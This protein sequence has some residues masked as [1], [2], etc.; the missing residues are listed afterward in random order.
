MTQIK[1]ATDSSVQLSPDEIA[2][3]NITIVPLSLMIDGTVYSDGVT[4]TRTEFMEKMAVAKALPKT[5]Q[6]PI[7]AF[8]DAYDALAGD[9]VE[10][11]SIHM[12]ESISGTVHSAEQAAQLS[13]TDVTVI[14]SE[15]TDRAMG[16]QVLTA[17][18]MAA[19]GK[20]M[21][22]ILARL[23]EIKQH[24]KLFLTVPML[25]N[26]VAGGRL[27]KAVGVIGGLLNIKV[28]IEVVKG[29]ITIAAKGR[30]MKT[31]HKY[32]D[33]IYE[34]MQTFGSIKRI[35]VSHAGAL[36]G[37]LVVAE[38]VRGMFPGT[39]VYIEQTSPIISTHVGPGV[40][41]IMYEYGE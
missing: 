20:S 22:E 9:D 36:E 13:K 19:E 11:L 35:G 24:T 38:K 32:F 31:I 18:K 39:E 10:V 16:F 23:E 3:N 41:A 29:H 17:A 5:S 33:H 15:V 28:V 26:L 25:D 1:I 6:P 4:I 8:V 21:A 37:A 7:G 34:E 40:V 2:E 14:D 27:N 30:G 12:M